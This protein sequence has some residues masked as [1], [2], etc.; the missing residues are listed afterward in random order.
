MRHLKF[1]NDHINL[2]GHLKLVQKSTMSPANV[3]P[4]VSTNCLSFHFRQANDPCTELIYLKGHASV[5]K[6]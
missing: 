5:D 2:Y 4:Q 3:H 6:I 1:Q